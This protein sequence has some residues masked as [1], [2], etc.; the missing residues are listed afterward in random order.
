MCAHG[1]G[2]G[3]R[4][5]KCLCVC[6][7]TCERQH[8]SVREPRVSGTVTDSTGRETGRVQVAGLSSLLQTLPLQFGLRDLLLAIRI[9]WALL[10]IMAAA[11]T[12]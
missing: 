6:E 5:Q 10:D 12:H 8:G 4:E 11:A 3:E 2:G 1:A 9:L 7:E